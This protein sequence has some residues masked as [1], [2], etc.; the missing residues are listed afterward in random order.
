MK[1][2][3]FIQWMKN[4]KYDDKTIQSR[5]SNCLRIEKYEGNLDNHFKKDNMEE[6][7]LKFQYSK[8]D[9]RENIKARHNIP[10]NGDVYNG[11]STFRSVIKLY[12]SFLCDEDRMIVEKNKNLINI[13]SEEVLDSYKIFLERFNIKKEELYDF[14]IEETILPNYDLAE[15]SWKTLKDKLFNNGQLYIRAAGRNGKGTGLYLKF[16]KYLFKNSNILIDPTNNQEPQRLIENFTGYK[17]NKNIYNYQ[18]S[19]IFGKTKNPLL[20][21]AAWNIALVPK[22]IDPFTGHEIKGKWSKEYQELFLKTIKNKYSIFIDEY[23]EIVSNLEL[24]I[25]LEKFCED[26]KST[27]SYTDKELAQFKKGIKSEFECI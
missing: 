3:A 13:D 16:Y 6:L 25:N 23:N 7:L 19:H 5:I 24:D 26:M 10:I 11:T 27:G 1:K 14:G 17:R 9:K 21:S 20:F 18:V 22:V 4:N 8:S 15:S 12:L 2:E